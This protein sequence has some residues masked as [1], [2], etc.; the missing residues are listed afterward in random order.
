MT[1]SAGPSFLGVEHSWSGR[2]WRARAYDERLALALAQR[3][4][5]PELIGRVLAGRS[6][7]VEECETFLEPRLRDCLPDPG[8]LRD[9][10]TAADR[11]ARAVVAG[12]RIAIFGDYDVD[13]ATASALLR[14]FLA[15]AGAP[16]RVYIPDRIAEG[17]GPNAPALLRLQG[18]GITL[19]ITVDCGTTAFEPLAAAAAA[20]LDVVVIDHHVAEARLPEAVAV[21][22]P[23]RIDEAP[24]LGHLAAVGVT[25]LLIVALNR[26]LRRAGWYNSSRPEP[27]L[28]QWLDLVALGT[29]CDMVP[30]TGLNRALV[31]QGLRVLAGRGNAGLNA[32]AEVAG[33]RR[34]ADAYALGFILGPRVN[35][36]GRLGQADLGS[37]LLSSDD[38]A[39]ALEIARMLERHNEDRRAVEAAVL[40][41]AVAQVE[42]PDAG[43]PPV[44]FA[45]GENWH[46]G[47][48]GIVA[49]RLTE[50]F[51]RPSCVVSMAGGIGKAS[52]RSVPGVALGPAV[53]A[54][55]QAGLLLAG[56]GHDM[57]AGFTVASDRLDELRYF[58]TERLAAQAALAAAAPTLDLDGAVTPA[59]ATI[60]LARQLERI[61]PYGA[62][63][64]E[65]RLA[66]PG[67]RLARADLVGEGHV[68]MILTGAGGGRLKA[69]AFRCAD[70][71]LGESL[72]RHGGMP[73]HLAGWLRID[74]WNG[75]ETAQLVVA[76]AAPAG[77]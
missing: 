49:S 30:L 40:E 59:A 56:G 20:G 27:D 58:L 70:T 71:P 10:D 38:P 1:A 36:G 5:A 39:E 68:R 48:I 29:V 75:S 14:R 52:G 64:A 37:R 51:A 60:E 50:R 33:L 18:E 6:V 55:R 13:G 22:N 74:H 57:A 67:A 45:V 15:A 21:V 28:L 32:L 9:M 63:H 2:R 44:L 66:V 76:D 53:I 41:E 31:A 72:L 42:A 47:V 7:G 54:A 3:L 46:P 24:G 34:R 8:R 61:G 62:G 77:S 4:G 26:A 17:Y 12:E 19:V 65:P 73:V 25:F 43:L 35:A 23:N 11:V 69:I 16:A